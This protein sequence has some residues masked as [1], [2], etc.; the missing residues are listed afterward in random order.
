MVDQYSSLCR[1]SAESYCNG[2]IKEGRRRRGP[3]TSVRMLRILKQVGIVVREP[4]RNIAWFGSPPQLCT[5]LW[6]WLWLPLPR[7]KSPPGQKAGGINKRG[8]PKGADFQGWG[9]GGLTCGEMPCP[10]IK[11]FVRA[12]YRQLIEWMSKPS[13]ALAVIVFFSV[14]C[15]IANSHLPLLPSRLLSVIAAK[16]NCWQFPWEIFTTI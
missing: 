4:S 16:W 2:P 11:R 10:G 9:R 5:A 14:T 13:S 7:N 6:V 1:S 8:N 12:N 15:H 3:R